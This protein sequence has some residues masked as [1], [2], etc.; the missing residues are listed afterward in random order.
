MAEAVR[1]EVAAIRPRSAPGGNAWE[2]P[3]SLPSWL[4]RQWILPAGQRVVP[5]PR[6]R[7]RR[8]ARPVGVGA[9]QGLEPIPAGVAGLWGARQAL[10]QPGPSEAAS[11]S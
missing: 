7:S 10:R 8:G 4:P 9:R 1:L 2:I 11:R 3:S 5:L 6:R